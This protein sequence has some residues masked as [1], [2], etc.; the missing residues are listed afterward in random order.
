M[1]YDMFC[2]VIPMMYSMMLGIELDVVC[3][4]GCILHS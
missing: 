3:G 2:V 1:F 4:L